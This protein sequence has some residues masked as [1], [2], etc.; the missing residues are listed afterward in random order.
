MACAIPGL[1][2]NAEPLPIKDF[3]GAKL[4]RFHCNAIFFL[5]ANK[6]CVLQC[7][8]LWIQMNDG[9]FAKVPR[10]LFIDAQGLI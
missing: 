10:H 8:S 4:V 6:S 2:P 3:S 7:G 9:K 5:L 1:P